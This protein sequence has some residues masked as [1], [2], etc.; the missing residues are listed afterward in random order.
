MH[1]M[2]V[3]IQWI[4]VHV[5]I[6][7][8]CR[9]YHIVKCRRYFLSKSLYF[10]F[11]KI[12]LNQWLLTLGAGL[13]FIVYPDVVTRLPISPLWSILFFVMMITLGMGSEVR[14][15]FYQL[16]FFL[17]WKFKNENLYYGKYLTLTLLEACIS[18]HIFGV[19]IAKGNLYFCL[20]FAL[21]ET[22]MTAVQDTFP[23]LRAKKTYVVAVVCLIGFLGGLSVTCNVSTLVDCIIVLQF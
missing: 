20:Q 12:K 8:L 6:D 13:A 10:G 22:M 19:L 17:A 11:K 7:S 4:W 5:H 9:V 23:Q 21:L 15:M 14:I 1:D 3:Q 16:N 18:I 2:T